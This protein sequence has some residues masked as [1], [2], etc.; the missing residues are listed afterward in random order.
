MKKFT[1]VS[2]IIVAVLGGIGILLCGIASLMGAGYGTIRRM[3]RAGEF[4]YGRWHIGEDGI[5]YGDDWEDEPEIDATVD[6]PEIDVTVD[7]PE[8]DV[9][10]AN[11]D[12][13]ELEGL[14]WN[15]KNSAESGTEGITCSYAVEKVRNLDVDI[16][17]AELIFCEGTKTDQI[18]VIL[19]KGREKYYDVGMDEDTLEIEYD[20][21]SRITRSNGNTPRIVVEIPAGM[22]FAEMD[23]DL[24]AAKATFELANVVCENLELDVGAGV[25]TAKEFTVTG[26]MDV[27][28]GVG[29][30]EIDGGTYRDIR[31]DCG[32]GDFVMKGTLNGNLTA[33]CGMGSMELKL[34]GNETDYNYRVS[35]SLGGIGVNGKTYSNISGSQSVTNPGAIGTIDLDCG[36]GSIDLEI[37]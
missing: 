17:A 9:D 26:T 29:S 5:Y 27:N 20:T 15:A 3:A 10:P 6:V 32:M 7:V 31:L 23:L 16:D 33:N 36:M 34:K 1:K 25:V 8:I 30:A 35:C 21:E 28:V 12:E 14:P 37:K 2:L 19:Q 11:S 18:V 13:V 24:G 22:T 4:N